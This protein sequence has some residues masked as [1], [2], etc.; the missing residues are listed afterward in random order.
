M[1]NQILEKF[2][3][4]A[5]KCLSENCESQAICTLYFYYTVKNKTKI[6]YKWIID[7]QD[8][9]HDDFGYVGYPGRAFARWLRKVAFTFKDNFL[10]F[11]FTDE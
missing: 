8:T 9:H 10:P 7:M 11:N 4:I 1:Q 3:L 6:D 2:E 5:R